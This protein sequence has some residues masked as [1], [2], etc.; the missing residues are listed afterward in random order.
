LF[1]E[2]L[3]LSLRKAT[4]I[5]FVTSKT[6]K[7]RPRHHSILQHNTPNG[8]FWCQL[9]ILRWQLYNNFEFS[10]KDTSYS[11]FLSSKLDEKL[12]L[13]KFVSQTQ[14][15]QNSIFDCKILRFK[16]VAQSGNQLACLP[17]Q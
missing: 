7:K 12:F 1:F 13:V 4:P 2:R 15:L 9:K 16:P 11:T 17:E 8:A 14:W 3:L 5:A 6:K 10:S